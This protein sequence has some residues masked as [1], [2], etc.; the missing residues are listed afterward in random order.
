MSIVQ[1][2]KIFNRSINI[3]NFNNNYETISLIKCFAYRRNK[4]YKGI[5]FDRLF[6]REINDK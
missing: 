2:V 6:R 5:S 3:V 4:K 1:D